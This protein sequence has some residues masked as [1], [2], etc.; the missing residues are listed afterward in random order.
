MSVSVGEV[1]AII[2]QMGAQYQ[3]AVVIACVGF[4]AAIVVGVCWF[5]YEKFM[6]P[7]ESKALRSA[8]RHK[9]A[10]LLLGG[11]DGY[12]DFKVAKFSGHEGW[13][14]T[15]DEGREKN[16][17]TGFLPRPRTFSVDEIKLSDEK[18]DKKKTTEVANFVSALAS[19]R[20]LLRGAKVPLWVAYRGKA[21]LASLY[22]LAALDVIDKLAE[23]PQFGSV[24]SLIDIVAIK[25]LFSEQWNESQINANETDMERAGELKSKKFGGKDSLIM[26]FGVMIG[27]IAL[28]IV[29]VAAVYFLS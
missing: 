20:L 10:L 2:S 27:V 9:K 23:S 15:A 18:Y 24:F 17:Y 28:A 3:L 14:K 12:G 1:E 13:Q 4:V 19:R 26:F 22:G 6:T 8:S 25:S 7:L 16:H 21:V 11:D 5:V 29:L